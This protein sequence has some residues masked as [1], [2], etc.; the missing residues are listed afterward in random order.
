MFCYQFDTNV[1][2]NLWTNSSIATALKMKFSIKDF[3][4]KCDQIRSFPR[5]WSYLLQKSLENFISC[6]VR[7]R[8]FL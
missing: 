5:I 2:A 7:R 4:S 1:T 8:V 6:V 3:S